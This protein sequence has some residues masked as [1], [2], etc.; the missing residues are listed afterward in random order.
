MLLR[1]F[2]T[3]KRL[4][5]TYEPDFKGGENFSCLTGNAQMSCVWLRLFEVTNDLRYLN[6]ALKINEMLKEIAPGRRAPRIRRWSRR[7]LSHMGQI[8]ADALYQLGSKISGRRADAGAAPDESSRGE[9]RR[10]GRGIGMRIAILCSSP[11]SETGCAVAASLARRGHVLVGAL[12]LP[13]GT[14]LR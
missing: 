5:G 8:S 6:A 12:S 1:K 9:I 3:N 7:L 4:R 11:Y 14:A 2:E 13:P 10:D